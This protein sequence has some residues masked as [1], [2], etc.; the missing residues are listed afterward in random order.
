MP[1]A[2]CASYLL[3]APTAYLP[4][5]RINKTV[6]AAYL[7]QLTHRVCSLLN[8]HDAYC[9]HSLLCLLLTYPAYCLLTV[10]ADYSNCHACCFPLPCLLL[11]YRDFCLL[12]LSAASLKYLLQTVL[13]K[14][15]GDWATR[16][17]TTI[18]QCTMFA[19]SSGVSMYS[20][21]HVNS[22]YVEYLLANVFSMTAALF[23]VRTSGPLCLLLYIYSVC[24]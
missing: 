1:V 4:C 20:A 21:D 22:T 9:A 8:V 13:T 7:L 15:L 5:L 18:R 23:I 16:K 11:T 10:P 14:C 2:Y 24:W 19:A 3:T 6:P 17:P 12:K